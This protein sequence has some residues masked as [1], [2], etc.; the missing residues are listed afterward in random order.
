MENIYKLHVQ[1]LNDDIHL[2]IEILNKLYEMVELM[3]I[4][5]IMLYINNFYILTKNQKQIFFS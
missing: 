3:K 2:T 5:K 1:F 4:N